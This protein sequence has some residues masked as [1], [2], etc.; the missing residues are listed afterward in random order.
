MVPGSL[1]LFICLEDNPCGTQLASSVGYT[2]AMILY[3]R[4]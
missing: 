2:A 3:T 4:K 1:I